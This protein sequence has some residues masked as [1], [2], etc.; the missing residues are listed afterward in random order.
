VNLVE[1]LY[2]NGC[3]EMRVIFSTTRVSVIRG[4]NACDT[5][6]MRVT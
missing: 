3:S 6:A 2:F 4:Q 1:L 5:R